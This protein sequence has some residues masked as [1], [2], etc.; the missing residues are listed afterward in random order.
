MPNSWN[1]LLVSVSNSTS[2]G[3]LALKMV[4]NSML[5]EEA[6]KR[7]KGD[8]AS[9]DAYVAESHDK[10]DNCG[11]GQGKSQHGKDQKS[12][13]ISKSRQRSGVTCFYCGK[14]RHKK[15]DC[16]KY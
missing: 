15:S 6:R 14:P 3:K 11:R 7:E 10:N 13:E 8:A 16:R 4:K 2:D 1:T 12:R 5:N 9:F